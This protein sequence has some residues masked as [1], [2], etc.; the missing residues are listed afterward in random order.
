[1][2]GINDLSYMVLKDIDHV[3]KLTI[4]FTTEISVPDDLT[5]IDNTVLDIEIHSVD[6]ENMYKR[7]FTWYVKEFDSTSCSIQILW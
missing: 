2:S 4:E 3:G 7:E 6:F 5:A 1:M